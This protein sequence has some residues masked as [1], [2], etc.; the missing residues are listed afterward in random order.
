MIGI[1]IK[2]PS[3]LLSVLNNPPQKL[4]ETSPEFIRWWDELK[5]EVDKKETMVSVPLSEE[6]LKEICNCK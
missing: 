6:N 1:Y 5:R 2:H 4:V 3:K